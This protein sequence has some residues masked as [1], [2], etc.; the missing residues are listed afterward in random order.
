[1]L[2]LEPGAETQRLNESTEPTLLIKIGLSAGSGKLGCRSHW[3]SGTVPEPLEK[4]GRDNRQDDNMKATACPLEGISRLDWR[5]RLQLG[6]EGTAVGLL[7]GLACTW[8]STLGRRGLNLTIASYCRPLMLRPRTLHLKH[9]VRLPWR[10]QHNFLTAPPKS[11]CAAAQMG[12]FLS[13]ELICCGQPM[14]RENV[15]K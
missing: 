2:S 5:P 14:S 10:M 12:F 13:H 8:L 15:V 3:G 7:A 11:S 6:T 1:M 9:T 4:A